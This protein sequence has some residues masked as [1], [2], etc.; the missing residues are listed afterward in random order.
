MYANELY[1]EKYLY[2]YIYEK[3]KDDNININI[4]IFIRRTPPNSCN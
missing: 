4:W 1:G 2:L 3:N